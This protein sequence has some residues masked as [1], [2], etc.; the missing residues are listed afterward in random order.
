MPLT[1][2]VV[3]AFA[4][5][6]A[7]AAYNFM[8]PEPDLIGSRIDD[9]VLGPMTYLERG[10]WVGEKKLSGHP[11]HVIALANADGMRDGHREAWERLDRGYSKLKSDIA[12]KAMSAYRKARKN[13][14]DLARV[15][16]PS[17]LWKKISLVEVH[18]RS[19]PGNY[20]LVYTIDEL[21]EQ[22]GDENAGDSGRPTSTERPGWSAFMVPV[23]DWKV[24]EP[25]AW[26]FEPPEN[27]AS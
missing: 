4:V 1:V 2:V 8:R 9:R 14:S 10:Q 7:V 23:Q 12:T 22:A 11:V 5:L 24:A 13:E 19:R 27:A 17:A 25:V 3:S 6:L 20:G 16:K 21:Y 26:L 15:E 18:L